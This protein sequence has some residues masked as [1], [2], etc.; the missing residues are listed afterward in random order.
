[1][2]RHVARPSRVGGDD[3]AAPAVL[4]QD[5]VGSV[6]FL[7]TRRRSRSGTRPVGVSTSRSPRPGVDAVLRRRAR[8]TTSKRRL[9]STICET[10]RPLD[11]RLQRL[12][13]AAGVTP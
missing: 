2:A 5:L 6:A 4:A 1:M 9:P 7:D 13:E 3:D 10:T 8:M 11:E 12:G